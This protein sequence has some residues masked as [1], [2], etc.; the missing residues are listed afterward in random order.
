MPKWLS[1]QGRILAKEQ[2]HNPYT[3][4]AMPIL[5]FSPVQII[6]GHPIWKD[7]FVSEISKCIDFGTADWKLFCSQKALQDILRNL[8]IH[9]VV[10]I[11]QSYKS[12]SKEITF[13]RFFF[14]E[15]CVYLNT[16]SWSLPRYILFKIILSLK[17]QSELISFE[18]F[19]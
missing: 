11:W 4:W 19:F 12:F 18:S 5:I 7:F 10:A 15:T 17:S 2:F 6:M 8:W 14:R 3:F 1:H 13:S 16:K 9:M